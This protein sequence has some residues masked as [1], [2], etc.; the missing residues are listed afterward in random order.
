LNGKEKK[1]KEEP[2]FDRRDGEKSTHLVDNHFEE[3]KRYCSFYKKRR[4]KR[5]G[6]LTSR[7]KDTG[8]EKKKVKY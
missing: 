8:G 5:A 2:R 3:A 6:V 1:I 4:M 7:Q